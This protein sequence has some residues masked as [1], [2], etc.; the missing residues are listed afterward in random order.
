[1]SLHLRPV[2]RRGVEPCQPPAEGLLYRRSLWHFVR[3]HEVKPAKYC[4]VQY[5]RKIC[6]GH[7]DRGTGVLIE[8]L[9]K[10]V[11]NAARLTDVV[12]GAPGRGKSIDLVEQVNAS[13]RSHGIENHAQLLRGLAH[14][15]GNETMEQDREKWELQF[16]C[17][18]CGAQRLTGAR[19]PCEQQ[20]PPRAQS[21]FFQTLTHACFGDNMGQLVINVSWQDDVLQPRRRITRIQKAGEIPSRRSQRRGSRA[22][23]LRRGPTY[24]G[25]LPQL[26][27][28]PR[29]PF[30]LLRSREL[31][32]EIEKA[33]FVALGMTLDE[34]NKLLCRCH[35]TAPFQTG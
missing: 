22:N 15:L 9:Q 34:P 2:D 33:L 31:H 10:R 17:E 26:F 24:L 11:Q 4:P 32:G 3:K 6:G 18:R 30:L 25:P 5:L 23:G 14:K 13:R 29:V 7:D 35:V 12:L 19:R 28:K 27:G 8:E 16:A 21:L 1:M 20:T